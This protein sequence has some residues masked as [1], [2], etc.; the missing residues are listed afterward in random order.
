MIDLLNGAVVHAKK[1]ERQHYQPIQSKLTASSE[2]IQVV[3][4]LL[5]VYPFAQLYIADLNAI[6]KSD[7][8]YPT[9]YKQIEEIQQAFPQLKLWLDVGISQPSD[10]LIWQG[11]DAR[12]V[13]GSENIADMATYNLL[14]T[15]IHSPILSLDFMPNGYQGAPSLLNQTEYWP[16]EVIV[17][18]LADVGA[19]SGPNITRLNSIKNKA[20]ETHIIAAGGIRDKTDLNNLKQMGIEGALVATA[21]HQKQLTH[22]DVHA[23]MA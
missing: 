12:M 21:L 22:A 20:A 4:A 2:P 8:H 5:S 6:Q 9:N 11:L 14:K 13:I 19:G 1:G 15:S 7:V 23:L 18:S 3:E 17:M 10:I 16:Q